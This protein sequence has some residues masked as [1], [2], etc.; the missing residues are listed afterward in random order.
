MS[1][2]NS[3]PKKKKSQGPDGFNPEFYQNFQG[4]LIPIFLNVFNIIETEEPLPNCFYEATVTMIPKPHKSSTKKDNYRPIS[5]MN[6][7]A[8]F[9]NIILEN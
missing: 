6:I 5:L 8:K 9:L 2:K 1:S 4:E 7:D 3:Q